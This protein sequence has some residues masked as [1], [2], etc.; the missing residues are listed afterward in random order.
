FTYVFLDPNNLPREIMLQWNDGNWEHRAY[1]GANIIDRGVDGSDSRR[2]MGR[3]PAAARWVRLEVPASLVGLEGRSI[4]GMAFT[5]DGA[6]ATWDASGKRTQ[7]ASPPPS[8]DFVWVDDAVPAGATLE[9]FNDQWLWLE[10]HFSGSQGHRSLLTV[11]HGTAQFRSHSFRNAPVTMNV[12]PG[13]ALFTYAYLDALNMPD[14]LVLQW[15]DGDGWEHRAFWGQNFY[16]AGRTGTE[17]RRF[18]GSMPPGDRW[19]RLEVPASYVG[20]EDKVVSGLSYGF[21]SSTDHAGINWDYSGKTSQPTLISI[22]LSA[23]APIYQIANGDKGATYSTNDRGSQLLKFYAYPAQAAGTVPFYRFRRPQGDNAEKFYSQSL[24]YDGSG[25]VLDSSAADKG[26]AFFVHADGSTPGT[27][28][29]F[30]YHD[31]LFHYF[32]TTNEAETNSAGHHA[33][34]IWAYVFATTPPVPAAPKSLSYNNSYLSWQDNATNETGFRIEFRDLDSLGLWTQL[35]TVDANVTLVKVGS[36]HR[37]YRVQAF[38]SIGNSS[39]SNVAASFDLIFQNTPPVVLV[40]APHDGDTVGR[41]VRIDANVFDEDGAGTIANVEFF[42]DGNKVGEATTPPYTCV[43]LN[44]P[45]GGHLLTVKATDNAGAATTSSPVSISVSANPPAF[46]DDFNDNSLDANKWIV[47]YPQGT[48][49][50]TEQSQQL[51]IALAPNTAGYN[52]VDSVLAYDLTGR[53]VQVEVPQVVS[54]A[55]YAENFLVI[56]LDA[57]NSLLIDVGTNLMFRSRVNGVNDQTVLAYDGTA[58]RHWR[59]RHDLSSNTLN[60]ETSAEAVVW[61]TRKTVSVGFALTNLRFHLGAG[62]W[63]TGNGSPG[64][65]KFDNFKLLAS[66]AGSSS[67]AITNF[68]FE[69]PAVGTSS[70]QYSPTGGIWTFNGGTG[71]SGNNSGF[72]GGLPAPQ[73][74]QAAFIQGGTASTFLQSVAGFQAGTNY[75]ITFAAIQRMNCCNA[76]GQD[77]QVYL[78]ANLLGSFH[79]GTSG[80]TDFSTSAFNTTAGAHTVKFLGL[81]PLGGDHTA[82]VDNVRISGNP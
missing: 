10:P 58:H 48:P 63:G 69:S 16:D 67:L 8:S 20:L 74:S 64:V 22:P 59:I 47:S 27:I 46:S 12:Q 55:G 54:Q 73:G 13:D 82:F 60:F 38:N 78:D 53:M 26:I 19:V 3:L 34:G 35:D 71:V 66:T 39:Y 49:P 33:D 56:D 81:N 4:N 40:T 36:L 68:G 44:A 62:A 42:V 23:T 65:A 37:N 18:M 76:G 72:T 43:W 51:Q 7:D 9:T 1:W 41:D 5:L 75:V 50:V 25:W 21:Y 24:A 32:L 14:E 45:L 52:G 31:D 15:Y 17:S 29:L 77:I 6:R 80:Y 28:P 2:Y 57:N 61:T 11:N 79:P 30:L 70:F